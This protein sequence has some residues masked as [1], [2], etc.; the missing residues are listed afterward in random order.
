MEMTQA[1]DEALS[2]LIT[3]SHILDYQG[4]VDAYGHIS[5]RDANNP[6]HF[7]MSRNLAPALVACQDDLVAYR[8]ADSEPVER[9]A[10]AGFVERA[11]HASI[12]RWY[13]GVNSVIHSHSHDVVPFTVTRVPLR[14]VYH[15]AGFL[16]ASVPVWDIASCYDDRDADAHVR[17]LLVRDNHIGDSLAA[18]FG[19]PQALADGEVRSE[20]PAHKVVLM[21]GHGFTTAAEDIRTA[22]FQAVYAQN[23]ARLQAQSLALT[24]AAGGPGVEFL[25]DRE[26]RDTSRVMP[27]T[28]ARPWGLWVK[29]VETNNLY[30]NNLQSKATAHDGHP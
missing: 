18:A 9:D 29:Q 3:A 14:P 10:P 28:S 25:N 26:I 6:G 27:K 16:G 30:T 12:Y 13:S 2:T 11:I 15:M 20:L 24:S 5:L 8:I 22:V 7:W 23:N 21:R 19:P 4:V 1:L 17:D